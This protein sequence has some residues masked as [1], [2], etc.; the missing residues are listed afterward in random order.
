MDRPEDNRLQKRGGQRLSRCVLPLVLM[1]IALPSASGCQIIIGVL[2]MIKGRPT[3]PADFE[4]LS[5]KSLAEK[6][7]KTV[8]LCTS[9]EKAKGEFKSL[10][11]DIIAEVS[12]RMKTH[13]ISVVEP[14]KVATYI[15]DNGGEI[16]D[17]DIDDLARKF[18][19][20]YVMHIEFR[21][22]GHKE[23]NSPTLYR[24]HAE[25]SISV[26]SVPKKDGERK[27]GKTIYNKAFT[28]KY[29]VHQP[30]SADNVSAAVFR[31][32][33]LERVSEEIARL[34]YEHRPGEEF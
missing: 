15:D 32:Q 22:F 5:G 17:E 6:G 24:G 13:E 31:K 4:T 8:V 3:L 28:S 30:V 26:L 33:Y 19:A 21:D 2:T 11:V 20:D 1:T 16:Q 12:R 34:F 9:P 23:E 7:K 10:D 29:P 14:H 18:D 27:H 25:G